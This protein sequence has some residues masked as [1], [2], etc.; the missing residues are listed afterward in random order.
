MSKDNTNLR[1]LGSPVNLSYRS[2]K[3]EEKKN[4]RNRPRSALQNSYFTPDYQ[5]R[6][7]RPFSADT[8]E[9]GSA[10]RPFFKAYSAELINQYSY[11]I[12]TIKVVAPTAELLGNT[13]SD[14]AS[15]K[16]DKEVCSNASDYG[17]EDTFISLGT[18]I[19]ARAQL[20]A[21]F[22]AKP[23]RQNKNAL[24]YRNI[25][26]KGKRSMDDPGEEK[27]NEYEME[28]KITE[29]PQSVSPTR[30]I[31]SARCL[32][33]SFKKAYE[34]YF[35]PLDTEKKIIDEGA[36]AGRVSFGS[37]SIQ[38]EVEQAIDTYS[39]RL[40]STK[41]QLSLVEEESTQDVDATSQHMSSLSPEIS[42]EGLKKDDN[43]DGDL[44]GRNTYIVDRK[45][46]SNTQNF[47]NESRT[48]TS[49]YD[50]FCATSGNNRTRKLSSTAI[51]TD[52]SSKDS[53]YPDSGANDDKAYT[54]NFSLPNTM[55]KKSKSHPKIEAQPKSLDNTSNI[56]SNQDYHKTFPGDRKSQWV[57]PL[58]HSRLLYKD[59]FLQKEGHIA[60][61]PRNSAVNLQNIPNE[62]NAETKTE[63]VND[64]VDYPS[65]LLNSTTKA[66]TCKVIEDYKK[67]LEAI[68]NLHEL[69]LKDIRTDT[70]SPTP[71]NIDKMF[72]DHSGTF[73]DKRDSSDSQASSVKSKSDKN[74]NTL[75]P[76]R[77]ISKVSTKELI[78]NYLKVKEGDFSK[79]FIPR[80]VKKFD[81]AVSSVNGK[82]DSC[83]QDWNNKNFKSNI[84]APKHVN[85]R[86]QT[87]KNLFTMRTP[88]SARHENV[89]QGDRDV[90]SWMSLSAPSPRILELDD[91]DHMEF[92][93]T[94]PAKS[95]LAKLETA[96]VKVETPST[97]KGPEELHNEKS[98]LSKTLSPYSAS[99]ANENDSKPKELDPNSTVL[100]IY[101]MLKEI[102][103]FGENPV[104]SVTNLIMPESPE[105]KK[106]KETNSPKDHFMEIFD[107]LEKVEQSANDA[108][109]V[110]TTN[111][112]QT[113][114][115]L[116]QLLKLPQ[117]ELAQR[118]VT[119]SLQLEERSCCIALLQE[120]LANHKE[121]MINK[122]SNL[123]KQSQRNINKIKLEC[124]E[125]IKR[126]QNFIDQLINDKKTLNHRIEQLVDE[127]RTLEERWKR[128]AQALEERYKLELRNQHDKMAAA[129]QVA[130]QRWVRQKAEKIKEL[131]VKGLEGELREMAERQHKEISDLKMY[132]AEY[133]G[134]LQARHM[135]EMEELRRTLEEEKES[136]LAK[137]R[138]VASSRLEKQI[139]ELELT[140]QEQR[141]R[142][143]AEMRAEN[144]RRAA[145]L[146]E[147]ERSQKTEF[148]VW[149]EEQEK[150]LQQRIAEM[151]QELAKEKSKVDELMEQ[152]QKDLEQ[153][154]EQYKKDFEAEQQLIMK[155]KVAEITTQHKLER[156]KEIEKAIESM[157]AEAQAGRKELQ[158]AL[159]RNK[160]QYEA[161][162]KE[163]AET[164]QATLRR[165]QE[166]QARIRQ[167][168]DRCAE[169]E[170]MLT[171]LETRN[172]V[173][174]EKNI[175]LE[176][177][178]EETRTRCDEAWKHKIDDLKSEM[179]ELKKTHE[180]QMHQLYAKVK[181]AV[182][183]KDSA[184]QAL[185][186][187]A[188]KYQEKIVLLEQ[189]LQQQ[190]KDFLKHK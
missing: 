28:I 41:Q 131:T 62:V 115:K 76:D 49:F 184:I 50:D 94:E 89:V 177:Q 99:T 163:L 29:R 11:P 145:E 44:T 138:Q 175:Q 141:T 142:L 169:M 78:Q 79:D 112:P 100:D 23:Q 57:E 143:V 46:D 32:S 188:A 48:Y 53:G 130:R 63:E 43:N 21:G 10:P 19:K 73:E 97:R 25:A 179:E 166:A 98:G 146:V 158:E 51:H 17:S 90:D 55:S 12:T 172:K 54:H 65:Y 84:P 61:P 92:E 42:L 14:N 26:K 126:H 176:K 127:R 124:E 88:V 110:V 107:F 134:K 171:Q 113:V 74:K 148:D 58:N 47:V 1:L 118:L 174:T 106:E 13:K 64:N 31:L 4:I 105:T 136:A 75:T 189:K 132:H 20:G 153:K 133:I 161:E 178:A 8:K 121:Q 70:I 56:S 35:L 152:K 165:Y 137:E 139:L 181:V 68:N 80:S 52:T 37:S 67:E 173:L 150:I 24:K 164:E 108:L 3:K 40:T 183:R 119:A 154:F 18:K 69:T 149:K 83:K 91:N 36:L 30:N 135:A 45:D 93:K 168:E 190:R 86:N 186:R 117:T 6:F 15:V 95:E 111:I 162:L 109:S 187:E 128:S 9:R 7:R 34:S 38:A 156:D 77:D 104:T 159:K 182:A 157:E 144:D 16:K 101:S 151:E 114:P 167:T 2:K 71:Y 27:N 39:R 122:V 116:E 180:E 123:E 5:E 33:P 170:V 120:S 185:T 85:I 125:T 66:Y 140:Y 60:L 147:R 87:Q 102:E 82:V 22:R 160:E 103:S 72:D 81:K 96:L 129:Q 59:F 155:K